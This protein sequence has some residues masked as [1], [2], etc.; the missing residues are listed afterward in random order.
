MY[1]TGRPEF[2]L[3]FSPAQLVNSFEMAMA[4][5]ASLHPTELCAAWLNRYSWHSFRIS[6]ACQL[7]RHNDDST[8]QTLCR[9]ATPT[10]M[11]RYAR[12]GRSRYS[13]LLTQAEIVHLWMVCRL[14]RSGAAVLTSTMTIISSLLLAWLHTCQAM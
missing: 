5:V 2:G 7:R 4:T 12:M 1:T 6:L 3:A 13:A 11:K 8:I 9:W 10:S 14:P